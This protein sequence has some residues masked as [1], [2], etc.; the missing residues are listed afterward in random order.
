MKFMVL[1]HPKEMRDYEAGKMPADEEMAEMGRF[2]EELVEAGIMLAGEG[3]HPSKDSVRIHFS[4]DGKN[5]VIKGPFS[6]TED[7]VAGYWIWQ[8]DSKEEALEWARK[9][10]MADGDVLEL[11]EIFEA[12]DFSPEIQKQEK[13]LKEK[14]G[15]QQSRH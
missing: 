13:R 12:A 5:S 3:L 9:A 4:S 1:V 2:N 15:S 14:M 6:I 11:R 8:V 7:F 10:P